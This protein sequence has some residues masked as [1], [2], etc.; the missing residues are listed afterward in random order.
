[1]MIDRDACPML[2]VMIDLENPIVDDGIEKA[3]K[4]YTSYILEM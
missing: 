4:R 2:Q 1:M 3:M